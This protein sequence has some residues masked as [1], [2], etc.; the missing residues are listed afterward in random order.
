MSK[1]V[2]VA[3]AH[4]A[5]VF[6]DSAAS[7]QKAAEW[8]VLAGQQNIELLVFPEVFLPGFP[9]W[10]NCYPPLIQ[11]ELNTQYQQQSVVADGPEMAAIA[12]ASRQSGV[13]VVM[14]LSERR[15]VGRT[16]HNSAAFFSPESGLIGIHRK[17]QP[18][19]AER[20]IWGQG[21]GSGLIAPDTP[22]G[23]ISALCCWEHT[24]NLARQSM[25]EMQ[26]EIHAALW[27]SL[28]TMAGFDEIANLQI[29]AMMRNHALSGGCFVISASS[30]V[31]Q[32]MLDFMEA[33]LGP[34]DFLKVGGGWSTVI[35]PFT[36][37][38]VEPHS[39][40]EEKLVAV[41]VDLDD[42]DSAKLWLDGTGHYARPEILKLVVDR[43]EKSTVEYL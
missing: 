37:S 41:T 22:V 26:A 43:R 3:A 24:M 29:E 18:T 30:P 5:P 38:L 2:K 11:A 34:Q 23:R 12:D 20:Y 17:L 6:M 1:Q 28:S 31:T 33:A 25:I 13:T 9:Y 10:I 15:Q 32:T 35:H 16:C 42:I 39:G 40:T 8:I 27:P 21:D 4:L 19:Y 14:G 7:A 36:A